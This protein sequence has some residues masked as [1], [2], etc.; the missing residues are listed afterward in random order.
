MKPRLF[1]YQ[2]KYMSILLI[3]VSRWR[4]TT[5]QEQNLGCY[6]QAQEFHGMSVRGACN[7]VR[8]ECKTHFLLN[9]QK[10]QMGAR[11]QTHNSTECY[12]VNF[13]HA[14]KT[15]K[16]LRYIFQTEHILSQRFSRTKN[17]SFQLKVFQLKSFQLIDFTVC[18]R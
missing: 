10:L 3:S 7:I 11:N 16:S 2:F 12:H 8:C 13:L 18:L 1:L 5:F 17:R 14:S 9:S 15:G 6:L 4:K